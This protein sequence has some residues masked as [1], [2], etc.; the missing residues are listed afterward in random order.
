MFISK[1]RL[2]K[3]EKRVADLEAQVQK[4]QLPM[5]ESTMHCLKEIL[6]E[7]LSSCATDNPS[8]F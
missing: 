5:S 1:K 3:L 7:R 6:L 4:Q 2:E 8:G